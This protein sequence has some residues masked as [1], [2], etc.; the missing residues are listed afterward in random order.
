MEVRCIGFIPPVV[1]VEGEFNTLRLGGVLFKALNPGDEVFLLDERKK[2]VFGKAVVTKLDN[3]PINEM[4]AMHG[5]MNHTQLALDPAHSAEGLYKVVQ[6]I[7][8]PHIVQPHK[9]A[10]VVY[11]KRT[12]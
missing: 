8:G 5:H 2:I 10:T 1:G 9:N 11:L 4:C 7:Y 12:E 6:K 3:G